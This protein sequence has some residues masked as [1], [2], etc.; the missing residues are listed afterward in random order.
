MRIKTIA[1]VAVALMVLGGVAASK[2]AAAI[3]IIPPS[4]EFLSVNPGETIT[5]KVKL[6]NETTSAV[7]MFSSA[8][9]FKAMD[10]SGTPK[11][12]MNVAPEDLASWIKVAP[13][14]FVLQ[15][16]EYSEI[17][18]DISVPTNADPG[19]HFAGIL[20]SP[21]EPNTVDTNTQVTITTEIGLLVMLRVNGEVR[22]SASV[23]SFTTENGKLKFNRLPVEFNVRIKNSGNVHVRPTG[24]IT[25]RNM[26]GGTSQVI[27]VNSSQG[28]VL[29]DSVRKFTAAWEKGAVEGKTNFFKEFGNEWNNFALGSYT[30]NLMLDYGVSNDKSMS[31]TL[32]F[33][34]MPWRVLLLSLVVIILI[35]ML[36]T[37]IVKQYNSWIIRKASAPKTPKK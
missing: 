31:V 4:R 25:V 34:V 3:T 28:A 27:P 23:L 15:P 10:E 29:P 5:T 16:G 12:I 7:E 32:R 8:A 37:F 30:A 9:N 6:F 35:T 17:P 22:E 33:W 18:F 19:G 26:L 21:Q 24:S 36:I 11:F 13:G 2:P 1:L 20:F 14:P